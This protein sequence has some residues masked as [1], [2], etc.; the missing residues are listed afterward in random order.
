MRSLPFHRPAL[1]NAAPSPGGTSSASPHP[2][3]LPEH[4][5][6]NLLRVRHVPLALLR[7]VAALLPLSTAANP[8]GLSVQSGSA[9]ASLNGAQLQITASHNAVLNWQSFN[10]APGETTRFH[11]PTASSVVW[12]QIQDQHPSQ[13]FGRLEA[14]GVV[15]LINPAGFYFGPDSLVTAAGLL[16]STA[17]I[18]PVESSAGL[19]WQFSGTPPQAAIVNYGRLAV[20]DAGSAFLIADRIENHGSIEAPGGSIGLAAGREV[21]LSERPDGRGL[22]AQVRLPAGSIDNQGRLI[23]DAGSVALQARVVNQAGLIQ[24]NS[25]RE[26]N[27]VIELIASDQLTLGAASTVRANGDATTASP[28]GVVRLKS[29]GSFQDN[30]GSRIEVTGGREGGAGGS[31]EISA[32]ALAAIH[33]TIDG[34]A[35]VGS[36]GGSLLID[37][38][39][40]VLGYSGTG[41]AGS[42]TVTSDMPPTTLSLDVNSAFTGFSQI[43]LQATR[44]I[45]LSAGVT[46]DLAASTGLSEP[47][48]LLHL[49]A[50]NN[51]TI[52]NGASL[53]AGDNWSI[54]LEAGRDF[55]HPDGVTPGVGTIALAGSGSVEARNGNVQLLAGNNITVA[56]GAIRTIAGGNIDTRAVAGSINTGTRA[57]GFRF[58]PTGYSVDP[59][60]GGISTAAGGNVQLTA[61]LDVTSYLPVAGGTQT[62]AGSGAFGPEPGNVSISAGRDVAG[63]FV[64]RNGTGSIDA[65]RNAGTASRLLA[66]SLVDGGWNVSAGQDVLLQEIRNPNGIFNNLGFGASPTRHLFDYSAASY[67]VLTAGR[68]VEL[69][70]TALPRYPDTFEEGLTPIY[71]G[72]LEIVAGAGGVVLGNDV[73]LF[74]SPQG[75]LQITTHEGGSLTGTRSGDLTQLGISDSGKPQ[76]REVG[77]FGIADHAATPLHLDD[78]EPVRLDI[79]GNVTG[80]L[81]GSPKRAEINVAGNLV[82][83]RFDGQNLHLDDTTR[84]HVAGDIINRNEFTSVDLAAAPDFLLFD[85]AYPPLGG[86]LGGLPNLLAYD[87]ASH[88]LT[89][90]GRMSGDQLQLLLNLPVQTFDA[91]DSPVLQPN[92]D[93]VTR[94]VQLIP[95]EAA[96]R[97]YSDSQDIPLN[98]DTGYRLGGPGR[99]ELTARSLDLGATVGVVS[100]G[101]RANPALARYFTRGADIAISLAGDLDMFSTQIASRNGGSI[102]V[103]ADGRVNV[104]SA[105]F[106]ASDQGARGIFTVDPSD[107]TVIARGDINVSGS[108]IA[109]YDGGNVT[110]RSLEGKV[111]AGTGGSGSASVEKIHVDPYTRRVLT[112][113]PTIPGSGI[114]ATTFPPSLD[115]A[116]PA[117]RNSVG[118]ILVETPRGDI[119]ASAGGVVQVPLNGLGTS[120]GTVILR[121]GSRDANGQ[122]LYRGDIDASGSGVIG[123]TV[124]LEASGDIKGLVFARESIDVSALRN[125]N[126][127]ALAQGSVNVSSGGNI[128]GT[129]I[130]VG[131]VTASGVG[132]VDAALLSQNISTSGNVTSGQVGFSQGTTANA[133]SQSVQSEEPAKAVASAKSENTDDPE[134]K[135]KAAAPRLTR[136]VGRVTVILPPAEGGQK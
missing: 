85:L 6:R 121:A 36:P 97:L 103:T 29:N 119:V 38:T 11:Q 40:I 56:A 127:T 43:H 106:A 129:I 71:P 134:L 83:S 28:G 70:G 9:N 66:L 13:I 102:S 112:Y 50:G 100:Q 114:L 91:S 125:V 63:H 5:P 104:G 74:P 26:R 57:V 34:H 14:N 86:A 17:P 113:A 41:V 96:N 51:L 60:L 19:F 128:S 87:A 107:V 4:T 132:N 24:A 32:L 117:S 23:A 89:F 78:F 30:S 45:T 62:D 48:S 75:N 76:Y 80:I 53:L 131:S 123:S 3:Y 25:V 79:S 73:T 133:T 81:L 116:F 94:M 108:R 110:V 42:G 130:G 58:L 111:D 31:L 101:P 120:A 77:D 67:A 84:L 61:G 95:P 72:R 49:E 124:K 39:D 37:P 88:R 44:N 46:W 12:N 64:V 68:A 33:S 35:A 22:S 82:N 16:V 105:T 122:V 55:S 90:Q 20:G 136:T 7:A 65:T 99:F 54:T 98:P 21:L 47:G 8:L 135:K 109:A 115:P 93:P 10:L 15:V 69:R 52:A 59:D 1:V 126:V 92:G 118:N 27:G 2:G 18:V